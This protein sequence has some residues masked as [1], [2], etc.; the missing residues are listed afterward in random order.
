MHGKRSLAALLLVL[1]G[2][3]EAEVKTVRHR[4]EVETGAGKVLVRLSIENQGEETIWVPREV[5]AE[6]ELTGRRFALREAQGGKEVAY[7]GPMVKR[8]PY[9]AGDYL[10]VAPHTT[11]VNTIDIGRAYAFAEGS[12]SYEIRYAGPYLRDL[13]RLDA[14][15]ESP[16]AALRFSY[17]PR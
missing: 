6:D 15:D 13:A 9:T 16:S 1:A 5:A 7:I 4:L 14:V 8:G 2:T 11:L 12:H 3:V 17:R 10:A